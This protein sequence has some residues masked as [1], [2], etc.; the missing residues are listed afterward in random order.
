MITIGKRRTKKDYQ[1][2]GDK[3]ER[4]AKPIAKVIDRVAG[5]NIQEC[6][7]CK[8]RKAWLN[9]HFP[10]KAELSGKKVR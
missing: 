1:G 2:L 8:K 9:K 10:G 6:G 5:T 7:G 3:V 4:V